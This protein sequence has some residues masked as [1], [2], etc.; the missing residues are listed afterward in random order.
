MKKANNMQRRVQRTAVRKQR[1]RGNARTRRPKSVNLRVVLNFLLMGTALSVFIVGG[2]QS[3]GHNVTT[4]DIDDPQSTAATRADIQMAQSTVATSGLLL[5]PVIFDAMLGYDEIRRSP[6]AALGFLLPFLFL[7]MNNT[8]ALQRAE[9]TSAAS[10][11]E[12]DRQLTGDASVMASVAFAVSNLA[13]HM[14]LQQGTRAILFALMGVLSFVVPNPMLPPNSRSRSAVQALQQVA[15]T[16][17][18]GLIVAGIGIDVSELASKEKSIVRV[19]APSS[20]I[21]RAQ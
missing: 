11:L 12:A 18:L 3:T 2:I 4:A 6:H 14:R 8:F 16:Y 5:W 20:T 7:T 17:A 15:L 19:P 10:D 9:E 1:R 13:I 21:P